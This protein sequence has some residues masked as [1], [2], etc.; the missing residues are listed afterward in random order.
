MED[1]Y[2]RFNWCEYLL[3]HE[4]NSWIVRDELHYWCKQ[5]YDYFR[6]DPVGVAQPGF[7]SGVTGLRAPQKH[8][9]GQ[10]YESNGLQLCHIERVTKTLR[11]LKK[12]A[13]QYRHDP[14]LANADGVFWQSEANRLWPNLRKP[15]PVVNAHFAKSVTGLTET[16]PAKLPFA[17]T[18]ITR[19][20]FNQIPF[21][22]SL[23]E[24][25]Q[26]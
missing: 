19:A 22:R 4:L 9:L 23:T 3:V 18:G 25:D 8:A 20:N 5:G 11:A 6:A 24:A 2:A 21:F 26:E 1:F 10:A 7:L 13:Y 12:T 16:N 15:T 14:T 17:L